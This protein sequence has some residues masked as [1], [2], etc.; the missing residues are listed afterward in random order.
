VA[1]AQI[2]LH[3][4]VEHCVSAAAAALRQQAETSV[5]E[6]MLVLTAAQ[7]LTADSLTTRCNLELVVTCNHAADQHCLL[8]SY[9]FALPAF[10]R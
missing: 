9:L 4:H 7:P 2:V 6:H 8:S 1:Y 3:V 10:D 5:V